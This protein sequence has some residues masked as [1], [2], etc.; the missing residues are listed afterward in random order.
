[1]NFENYTLG[2]R[3]LH[4]SLLPLSLSLVKRL[5]AYKFTFLII[6]FRLNRFL[7]HESR[8]HLR[9]VVVSISIDSYRSTGFYRFVSVF[10]GLY[11]LLPVST[12]SY[13]SQTVSIHF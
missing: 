9:F 11:R 13:R 10:T 8:D 1:M 6:P 7:L 4:Q 2:T 12:D 5:L 3:Q